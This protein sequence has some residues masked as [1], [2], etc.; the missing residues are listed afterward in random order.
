[1]EGK[2]ATREHW[3]PEGQ[4]I[5]LEKFGPDGFKTEDIRWRP[6]EDGQ[7]YYQAWPIPGAE[8]KYNKHDH[9][10]FDHGWPVKRVDRDG[11]PIY[12]KRG[13]DWVKIK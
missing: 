7:P 3:T 9:W 4:P 10:F 1:M 12:E 2:L 8:Y 5:A 6:Y 11:R 13:D